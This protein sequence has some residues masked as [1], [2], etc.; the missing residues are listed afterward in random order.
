LQATSA[1]L[2]TISIGIHFSILNKYLTSQQHY[3]VCQKNK[4][5][6]HID[7]PQSTTSDKE[8]CIT[9]LLFLCTLSAMDIKKETQNK[10]KNF[11][12]II[13]GNFMGTQMHFLKK[14]ITI[15]GHHLSLLVHSITRMLL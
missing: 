2:Y 12:S 13:W 1:D 15:T 8:R 6:L 10:T 9:V 3:T 4:I 7:K 11:I 14:T 5:P